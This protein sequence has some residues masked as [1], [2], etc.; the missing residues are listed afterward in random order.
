MHDCHLDDHELLINF[1]V[2]SLFTKILVQGG[3]LLVDV[4]SSTE[5]SFI[6]IRYIIFG[7]YF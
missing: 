3:I 6:F 5:R 1:D 2:V 4:K 7:V